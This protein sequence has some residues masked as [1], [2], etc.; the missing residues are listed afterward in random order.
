M[1]TH[2][3][4]HKLGIPTSQIS[5]SKLS[6]P[7]VFGDGVYVTV[8]SPLSIATPMVGEVNILT[9][10]PTNSPSGSESSKRTLITTGVSSV[11]IVVS[12][13]A[14]GGRFIWREAALSSSSLWSPSSL[15]GEESI[16]N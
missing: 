14:T 13:S 1:I 15:S 6:T 16:S 2:A 9:E 3:V 10:S 4:S 12:L 5:Y 8:L 11:V 7:N